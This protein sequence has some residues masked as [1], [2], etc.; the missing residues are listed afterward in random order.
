MEAA[1]RSCCFTGA[2][3]TIDLTFGPI[4]AALAERHQVIAVELQGHGHTANID[5]DMTIDNLADD[6]VTL[7]GQLGIDE[8]D[9]FGF[10]LGGLIGLALITPHPTLVRKLVVASA[11]FRPDGYHPDSR[12]GSD[13]FQTA[14]DGQEW[15][16][17]YRRVAPHPDHFPELLARAGGIVSAVEGWPADA[18]RAIRSPV[19]TLIGDR[20][21]V[22]V[23]HA[24]MLK[25]IPGA[26][27]AVLPGTTHIE[28]TRRPE[29]VLA[30]VRPFLDASI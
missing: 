21:F 18:L 12:P 19:L 23:E 28:V 1:G 2:L 20:D 11:P 14:A 13:R 22:S 8:A 30:L 29:Q 10:S 17:A 15:E 27:L 9:F 4:I 16:D 7:L 25:L 26:Q 6:V 24:E 3:L 5:R